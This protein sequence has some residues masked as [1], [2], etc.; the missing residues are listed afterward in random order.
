[1]TA[2]LR[3]S[4]FTSLRGQEFTAA[5]SLER[6]G[7]VSGLADAL[8]C[9]ENLGCTLLHA[10]AEGAFTRA[11]E[12]ILIFRGS[13]K[14]VA[15]AEDQVIGCIAKPSGIARAT[16]AAV[17]AVEGKVRIV[18]GAGKKMP[19]SFKPALRRAVHTGGAGGCI[20]E[21]PFVYLDKNYVRMFGSVAKTLAGVAHMTD[22]VRVIQIRGLV[23]SIEAE[24]LAAL[25]GGAGIL[26]VDTGRIEDLD[27]VSR[28]VKEAGKRG[29]VALAFAG[30]ITLE[31]IPAIAEH[32][33]D[34]LD[35]GQAILDAPLA[36][37]KLDVA[38]ETPKIYAAPLTENGLELNLLSKT[39]L[40]IQGISLDAANLTDIAAAVARALDLPEDK[41]AVIDVR[42]GQVALDVLMPNIAAEQFFGR[43]KRLLKAVS[44]LPGVTL[45]NGAFVHS[46]GILGAISLDEEEAPRALKAAKALAGGIERI[47]IARARVMVFP[48]GFELIAKNIQ[49]TN[50]P[51]LCK[52][53]G[54][55]GLVPEAGP[56]LPDNLGALV[57]ALG[58]AAENSRAVVTT[59]GVGAED[60]DFSVE[61]I[62]SLDPGA[63]APYLVKFARGQGRHVKDGIRIAV[64]EY[65][66]CIIAALPGPHDEVRL[67]GPVLVRGVK[68]RLGKSEIAEEVASIL[69][70]KFTGSMQAHHHH[71][72]NGHGH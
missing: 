1:M 38:R 69:R 25:E 22:F 28:L 34:I 48:T 62:L 50:T 9:L 35:I 70:G 12:P 14:A 52:I 41:I 2:D 15:I 59:G 44:A 56:C 42:P 60:K 47:N 11:G 20:C 3:D 53:F 65:K 19:V 54:E 72:H 7:L 49:D 27:L 17:A 4:I 61:A 40:R 68:Q 16:A 46:E 58:E 5:L 23:E 64:G 55:A 43:E 66:G 31:Q 67:A 18:A 63:A 8:A 36:D 37:C 39:E 24:T 71:N 45:Q 21:R 51:Y 13:A 6:D 26:M 10:H 33:V 29:E 32:D 30:G 57:K